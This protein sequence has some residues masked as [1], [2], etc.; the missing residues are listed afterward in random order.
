MLIILLLFIALI[1]FITIFIHCV[2]KDLSCIYALLGV[3]SL[4]LSLV[5][6]I[7]LITLSYSAI[8]ENV[9]ANGILASKQSEYY[10]LVYQIENDFYNNDNDIGKKA[11]YD[12]IQDWNCEVAKGQNLMDNIWVGCL[13]PNKI[14][15]NL[16]LIDLSSS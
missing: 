8:A 6:G 3:I 10:S 4:T 1:A 16:Q 15:E 7:C 9:E 2:H 14:Y 12:Q 11:L 13:Y 5:I